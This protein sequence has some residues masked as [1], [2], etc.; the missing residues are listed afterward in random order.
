[1]GLPHASQ[2][3]DKSSLR[4]EIDLML[5]LQNKKQ[6]KKR[7]SWAVESAVKVVYEN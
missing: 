5:R 4:I 3:R 2:G 7:A 6:V 1:M